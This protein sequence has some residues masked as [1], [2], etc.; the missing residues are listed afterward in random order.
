MVP[1]LM[2]VPYCEEHRRPL[3]RCS[4]ADL[5]CAVCG[6]G[7]L[8]DPGVRCPMA[9]RPTDE[10]R[11]ATSVSPPTHPGGEKQKGKK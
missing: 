2:R 1:Y 9:R 4:P 11:S 10:E 6:C 8:C 3:A 5:A 7:A